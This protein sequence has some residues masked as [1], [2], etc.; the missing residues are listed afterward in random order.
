MEEAFYIAGQ[1][2]AQGGA[3][4]NSLIYYF[5][6]PSG[7]PQAVWNSIT[8]LTLQLSLPEII[9]IFTYTGFYV[10]GAAIFSV[11]WMK[12]SGQDP[13][14][15]ADQIM[16]IGMKVPGFRKDK[17][18]IVKILNRYIPALSVLGGALIGFLAAVANFTNAFGSGT[19]ILLAVFISF[20]FYEEIVKKHMEDMHPALRNFMGNM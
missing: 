12:T 9:Q 13:S 3:A 4:P 17:R 19:G 11:F 20:Q 6:S 18:V 2:T 5:T 7:I 8:S 16:D 1:Y 15:V 10:V 14:S